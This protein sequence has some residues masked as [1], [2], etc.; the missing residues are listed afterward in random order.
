MRRT[1]ADLALGVAYFPEL[2]LKSGER[3][4]ELGDS[5]LK[6]G[7]KRR[8]RRREERIREGRTEVSPVALG[9]GAT[10]LVEG[11]PSPERV[12]RPSSSTRSGLGGTSP[13]WRYTSR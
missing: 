11:L 6:K 7:I 4:E 12:W 9:F 5:L 8:R 3:L 13:R 1:P 10:V 2:L